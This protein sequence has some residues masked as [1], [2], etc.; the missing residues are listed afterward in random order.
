M[1]VNAATTTEEGLKRRECSVCEYSE[2][3]NIP[4]KELD[5]SDF[6]YEVNGSNITITKY[7]G[8]K[9]EVVIPEGVTSIGIYAFSQCRNLVSV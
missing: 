3:R 1:V 7:I 9:T 2:S 8:S 5:L 4:V 6:K